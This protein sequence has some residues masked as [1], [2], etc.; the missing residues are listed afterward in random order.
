MAKAG[1]PD[2]DIKGKE[3]K[4]NGK[5]GWNIVSQEDRLAGLLSLAA[6]GFCDA[7]H[8][9]LEASKVRVVQ[10]PRLKL[11]SS[12]VQPRATYLPTGKWTVRCSIAASTS[13][14]GARSQRAPVM[15]VRSSA[16]VV[17]IDLGNYTTPSGYGR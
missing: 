15:L 13:T 8:A 17:H 4:Q 3:Q 12:R 7:H 16:P 11:P 2:W 9:S 6:C 10:I 14:S 1:W 5:P